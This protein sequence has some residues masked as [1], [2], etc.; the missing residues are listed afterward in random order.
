M[1]RNKGQLCLEGVEA[2]NNTINLDDLRES[3]QRDKKLGVAL[4][5]IMLCLAFVGMTMT[6]SYQMLDTDA[7]RYQMSLKNYFGAGD[8]SSSFIEVTKIIH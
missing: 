2:T 3:K 4:R 5:E 1:L 7:Y 6:V 8:K